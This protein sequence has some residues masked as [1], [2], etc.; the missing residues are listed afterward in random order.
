MESSPQAIFATWNIQVQDIHGN[1]ASFCFHLTQS[2]SPLLLGHDVLQQC[3]LHLNENPSWLEIK[4]NPTHTRFFTY[5]QGSRTRIEFAP[6]YNS[7]LKFSR[8]RSTLFGGESP[9]KA[10]QT[11]GI[12][13]E[14]HSVVQETRKLTPSALATRLHSYSHA[15][16]RDLRR[17][18]SRANMLSSEREHALKQVVQNCDICVQV[19]RPAPSRKVSPIRIVAEFNQT[20]QVDFMFITI[21]DSPLKL[22]HIVDSAT[23]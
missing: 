8:T 23:A 22:F 7:C 13:T 2:E 20:V 16:L 17:L 19:G 6:I 14:Q 9:S 5:T 1:P 15:P 11:P 3:N 12:A 4:Q 21:R 10:A 18:L